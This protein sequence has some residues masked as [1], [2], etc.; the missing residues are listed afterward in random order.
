MSGV[1][2]LVQ[3]LRPGGE[4]GSRRRAALRLRRARPWLPVLAGPIL[5]GPLRSTHPSS[6]PAPG[7]ALRAVRVQ[8]PR[9]IQDIRQASG[10]LDRPLLRAMTAGGAEGAGARDTRLRFG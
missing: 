10:L 1:H 6:L 8:A 5:H 3:G 2:L 4:G 7:S 9:A